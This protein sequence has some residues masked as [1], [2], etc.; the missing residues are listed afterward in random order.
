[1]LF[2]NIAM[3]ANF[4][5]QAS[6]AKIKKIFLLSSICLLTACGGGGGGDSSPSTNNNTNNNNNNNSELNQ[7]PTNV[8]IKKATATSSSEVQIEWDSASDDKTIATDLSYEIHLSEGGDFTVSDSTRKFSGKNVLNA[9]IKGLKAQTAYQVKLIAIDSQG[10]KTI[11]SAKTVTTLN[12]STPPINQAPTNVSL[13]KVTALTTTS[14]SI[15]WAAA[16]D[17]STLP[18]K[19]VYEV[20]ITEGKADFQPSLTTLKKTLSNTLSTQLDE[21]KV[22]TDYSVKLLVKDEQG[23]ST[24]SQVLFVTTLKA[25][26]VAVDKINDTGITICANDNTIFSQCNVTNLGGWFN[27]QQDGQ[28]GRD[29][30]A[31]QKQLKKIGIGVSGFDFSKLGI[32]GELLSDN[33]TIWSCVKDNLTGLIWEVKT[34]DKALRDTQHTY[35]WYNTDGTSNGGD[36]G[37]SDSNNTLD[38]TNKVNQSALCGFSDWRLPSRQELESILD[39]GQTTLATVDNNLFLN[40]QRKSY[41]TSTTVAVSP[42][43]AWA[44]NFA[45]ASDGQHSKSNMFPVLLVRGGQ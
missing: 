3:L 24:S 20:H 45:D 2:G 21:L 14:L 10:L 44:I 28:M 17:D 33:A 40:M 38:Y 12:E 42:A 27:W 39:Y 23:L 13:A 37:K 41:W 8:A 16:K 19:L 32:K 25:D 26:S 31:A 30:L 15:E 4:D 34:N 22:Q 6:K 29:A 43:S 36:V 18:E 9:A 7:A 11:S 5:K 1:M 35:S